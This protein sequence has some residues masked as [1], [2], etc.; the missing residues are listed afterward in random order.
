MRIDNIKELISDLSDDKIKNICILDNNSVEFLLRIKNEVTIRE[1]FQNYDLVLLPQWVE[2][3]VNDS[4]YRKNYINELEQL[5][6][7]KFCVISE[8][9]YLDL[10]KSRD[11]FLFTIFQEVIRLDARLNGFINRNILKGKPIEDLPEYEEWINLFYNNAFEQEV[12]KNHRIKRK[13]AG[14][15]SIAVLS[16]IISKFYKVEFVTVISQ[17]SGTY[18]MIKRATLD[19]MSKV[20][21]E[22]DNPITF[23]S[24]D[25]IINEFYKVSSLRDRINKEISKLRNPRRL[26]YI[27]IKGD[28]SIEEICKVISNEEFLELLE[29]KTV[30]IIF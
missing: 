17:D 16:F 25:C 28:T 22:Y 14:E 5:E 13:N 20:C 4:I 21:T 18:E 6:Y 23:K 2:V 30:E 27:K 12:L 3:E 7:I 10:L 11:G 9:W 24:N 19:V 29:D 26:K 15:I 1:F 8:Y